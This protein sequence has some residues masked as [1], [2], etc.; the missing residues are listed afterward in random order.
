MLFYLVASFD[1]FVYFICYLR[2]WCLL[3]VICGVVFYCCGL[4]DCCV[5][6]FLLGLCVYVVLLLFCLFVGLIDCVWVWRG[7]VVVCT[8]VVV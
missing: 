3:F 7:W 5:A 2:A 6:L 1:S 8:Y 4:F